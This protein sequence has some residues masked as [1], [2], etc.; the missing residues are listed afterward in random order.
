M[1][2]STPKHISYVMDHIMKI[3]PKTILDVGIGYGK[4]GF[5]CREYLE[6]WKDRV[7]P[8]QWEILLHGI[9]I[10]KPYTELPWIESIYDLVWND[11]LTKVIHLLKPR[12]PANKGYDLIIAGDVIEHIRKDDG[13]QAI[14]D[15]IQISSKEIILS[16]PL[17]EGW[18]NNMIVADN[19][20]ERHRAVW[21]LVDVEGVVR[22]EGYRFHEWKIFEDNRRNIGVFIIDTTTK[23]EHGGSDHGETNKEGSAT[24]SG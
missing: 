15:M 17:G 6:A 7:F 11:D 20:A 19:E 4:W 23:T 2:S 8:D 9:E 18:M 3:Q 13:I 12:T 5:L 21:R 10:F 1:P 16:I 14:K 22:D 24:G